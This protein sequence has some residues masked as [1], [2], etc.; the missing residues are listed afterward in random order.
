MYKILVI[1]PT[2]R[3]GGLEM[4]DDS[5]HVAPPWADNPWYMA[6][7]DG[8]GEYRV[9]GYNNA[10][11]I[12]IRPLPDGYV[13]VR[14]EP[15]TD[16]AAEGLRQ[17][18]RTGIGWKQPCYGDPRRYRFS[19]MAYASESG[20]AVVLSAIK[21]LVREGGP[22]TRNTKVR[23]WRSSFPG[24]SPSLPLS[25]S[26]GQQLLAAHVTAAAV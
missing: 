23:R 2:R 15:T 24:T 14:V 3:K 6:G 7:T 12:G 16:D 17:D 10:G 25:E 1:P 18:L 13:R 22:L 20:V 5:T 11:R 19:T 26:S 21:T 4:T 8:T 9:I